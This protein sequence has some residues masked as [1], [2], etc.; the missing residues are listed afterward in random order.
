MTLN[1]LE[2]QNRG[3]YGFLGDFGLR[4]TLGHLFLLF[5]KKNNNRQYLLKRLQWRWRTELVAE[6]KCLTENVCHQSR[7]APVETSKLVPVTHL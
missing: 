3:F 5:K 2:R 4:N 7:V 6:V 1:D